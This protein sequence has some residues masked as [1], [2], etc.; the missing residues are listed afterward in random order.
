MT[1]STFRT[2]LMTIT[3]TNHPI[4]GVWAAFV[5]K[6]SATPPVS[7]TKTK[8]KNQQNTQLS[9]SSALSSSPPPPGPLPQAPAAFLSRALSKHALHRPR[10]FRQLALQVFEAADLDH[11]GTM[12]FDEVYE[13]T[14]RLYILVNRQAPIPPPTRET[15]WALFV[16]TDRDDSHVLNKEEFLDFATLLLER[17]VSRVLAFKMVTLV[18]APLL[19]EYVVHWWTQ[20]PRPW[21]PRMVARVVTNPRYLEIVTSKGFCRTALLIL[22]ISTLGNSVMAIVDALLQFWLRRL[23]QERH[24]DDD[25]EDENNNKKNKYA[26]EPWN[27]PKN[28]PRRTPLQWL[29]LPLGR[30]RT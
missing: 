13:L 5:K 3:T 8:N 12:N 25:D 4:T 18:G 9:S 28:Q 11:D 22:F 21:L 14:L 20:E 15:T 30:R 1:P 10:P 19:T 23:Q 7:T 2:L 24:L 29:A 17:A 6:T 27:D 26:L 16:V